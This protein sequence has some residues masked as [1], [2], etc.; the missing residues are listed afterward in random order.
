[1][2][3]VSHA[4]MALA[5]AITGAALASPLSFSLME[6]DRTSTLMVRSQ[7]DCLDLQR[8]CLDKD[9]IGERGQG[10]CKRYRDQC[11]VDPDYCARLL[12]ACVHKNE[13]GLT[14]ERSCRHYRMECRHT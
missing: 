5:I 1:M 10:N 8:A 9:A 7:E 4:A 11:G 12:T 2:T 14:G 6:R 13:L 3:S